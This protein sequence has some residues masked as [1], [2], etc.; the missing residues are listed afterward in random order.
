[1]KKIRFVWIAILN[2]LLCVSIPAHSE[3]KGYVG[4]VRVTWKKV[5]DR[6]M[7]L[8]VRGTNLALSAIYNEC[9]RDAKNEEAQENIGSA[10]VLLFEW[11][12]LDNYGFMSH[13]SVSMEWHLK[14]FGSLLTKR[15][16]E[17]VFDR[18]EKRSLAWPAPL[19]DSEEKEKWRQKFLAHFKN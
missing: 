11:F 8:F 10:V 2:S 18:A 5:N 19:R 6:E 17:A 14:R 3:E 7:G 9:K 1:M 15:D 13:S 4:E 16:V 12:V